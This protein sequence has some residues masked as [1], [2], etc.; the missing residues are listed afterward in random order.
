MISSDMITAVSKLSSQ[1]VAYIQEELTEKSASILLGYRKHCAAA[2]APSQ[3]MSSAYR[4]E[5]FSL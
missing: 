4:L 5:V 2:T 1:K 3:V